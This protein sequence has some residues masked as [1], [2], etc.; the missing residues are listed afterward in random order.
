MMMELDVRGLANWLAIYLCAGKRG[1]GGYARRRERERER[2]NDKFVHDICRAEL[3]ASL[4]HDRDTSTHTKLS[5]LPSLVLNLHDFGQLSNRG[6]P[7][8]SCLISPPLVRKILSSQEIIDAN[9]SFP[10]YVVYEGCNLFC[11]T[12]HDFGQLSNLGKPTYERV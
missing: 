4:V 11:P 3:I 1:S 2:W 8:C 10:T 7:T 6:K 9:H 12:Y 5:S